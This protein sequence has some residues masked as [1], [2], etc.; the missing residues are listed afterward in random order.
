MAL[1]DVVENIDKTVI[2]VYEDQS[3]MYIFTYRDTIVTETAESYITI[4]NESFSGS[5][6]VNLSESVALASGTNVQKSF[7]ETFQY[8]FTDNAQ[9]KYADLKAGSFNV[10]VT[11]DFMHDV[12]IVFTIPSLKKNGTSLTRTYNLPYTGIIP[13][14][15]TDNIDLSGYRLDLS[16]AGTTTNSFSFNA[17]VSVTSSGNVAS[18]TN[19][20][21]YSFDFSD[22]KFSLLYGNVGLHALPEYKSAV[23]IEIFEN[24]LAGDIYF[25]D[26]RFKIGIDNSLG[27]PVSFSIQELS[28]ETDYGQVI[29]LQ[30][31]IIPGPNNINYPTFAQKGTFAL[32]EYL[33]TKDNGYNIVE[34][35]NPAP[36]KIRYGVTAS[37]GTSTGTDFFVLDSSRIKL[38]TEAEIP[39]HGRIG[40]FSMEDTAHNIDL[41]D[42]EMIQSVTFKMRIENALP[43]EVM[44]QGYWLDSSGVILDSLIVPLENLITSGPVDSNGEVISPSTKYTEITYD[45]ERYNKIAHAKSILIRGNLRTSANGTTNVKFFSHNYLKVQI[46]VLAQGKIA[47]D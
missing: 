47:F 34:A 45:T 28:G 40:V 8:N 20:V 14:S 27:V 23:T 3:G 41:P 25:A 24:A 31:P 10:S 38:Y 13:T 17:D 30:G 22:L 35:L 37:V 6:G 42:P 16:E 44:A 1:E 5:Y 36:A 18:E 32:T 2:N 9:V 21:S 12:T 4:P 46:S 26:P 7:S 15:I 11:S 39:M 29:P 19:S 33:L 43:V